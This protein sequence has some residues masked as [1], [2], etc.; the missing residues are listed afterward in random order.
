MSDETGRTL[1]KADD[2]REYLVPNNRLDPWHTVTFERRYWQIEHPI[3]CDLA[4]CLFDN[5]AAIMIDHPRHGT[6]RWHEPDGPLGEK[7]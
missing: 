1:L 6:Y 3:T 5:F 4:T 2:G 7:K